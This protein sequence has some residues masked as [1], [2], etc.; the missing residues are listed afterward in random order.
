MLSVIIW[1]ENHEKLESWYGDVLGLKGREVTT[2]PN[3]TCIGF[4][5][6][7]T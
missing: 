6:G 7:D 4:D 2:H 3:D 5:F 1:S